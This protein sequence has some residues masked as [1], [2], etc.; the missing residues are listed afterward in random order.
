MTDSNT[1]TSTTAKADAVNSETL[2]SMVVLLDRD[3]NTSLPATVFD[4]ELPL[5][6]IIYGEDHYEVISEESIEIED[7]DVVEAYEGLRRKYQQHEAEFPDLRS[8][9]PSAKAFGKAIGIAAPDNERRQPRSSVVNHRATKS[10]A[11][12]TAK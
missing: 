5:L 3:A 12:K 8:V 9:Y 6:D 4:Y 7:F 2:T 1:T 10:V 11:K